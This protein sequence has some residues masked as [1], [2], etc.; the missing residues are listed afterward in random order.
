MKE[1]DQRQAVGEDGICS[2][3][4]HDCRDGD[5]RDGFVCQFPKRCLGEPAAVDGEQLGVAFAWRRDLDRVDVETGLVEYQ[6]S[7][8][9]GRVV[10]SF[11]D[12]EV[13]EWDYEGVY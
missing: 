10:D 12:P 3:G 7:H 8:W 5:E 2:A 1:G 9:W 13:E 4:V 11:E 6:F